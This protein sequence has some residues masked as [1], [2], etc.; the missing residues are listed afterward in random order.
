MK[1]FLLA[2]GVVAALSLL[3]VGCDKPTDEPETPETPET[4]AVTA[5]VFETSSQWAELYFDST[6][7]ESI[8]AEFAEA[9]ADV[10]FKVYEPEGYTE[11]SGTKTTCTNPAGNVKI[12]IQNKSDTTNTIKIV[13]VTGKKAD[14]SEVALTVDAA[15]GWGWK[16]K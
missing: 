11:I 1:K 14:G 3:F 4:P 10:Q 12:S 8:T 6:G 2:L 15:N 9:P 16:K 13:K 5:E 7:L